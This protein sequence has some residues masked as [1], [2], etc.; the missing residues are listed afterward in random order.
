MEETSKYGVWVDINLALKK[1]L[2]F[3][4]TRSNAI[5]LHDA[6]SGRKTSLSQEIEPRSVHEEPVK[7]DRTGAP[8][9]CRDAIHAQGA[10]PTRSSDDSKSLN[11]ELARG[12]RSR[13]TL[14]DN[15][16]NEI[17]NKTMPTTHI[18]RSPRK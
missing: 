10:T 18:V 7:Y 11:V 9:V 15:L 16:F 12:R 1:G 8:V 3:Y 17:Y 5:I 13:T 14:T 6:Q 2:K 4:Q